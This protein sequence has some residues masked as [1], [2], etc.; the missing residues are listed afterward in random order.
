MAA[1]GRTGALDM[2]PCV[3]DTV[4]LKINVLST[5]VAESPCPGRKHGS[6]R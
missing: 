1:D 2:L 6:C 5:P 4:E 3:V